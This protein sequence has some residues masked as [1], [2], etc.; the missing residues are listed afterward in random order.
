MKNQL[1]EKIFRVLELA[2]SAGEPLSRIAA[3]LVEADWPLLR[4]EP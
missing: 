3:D 1:L 4:F 2:A